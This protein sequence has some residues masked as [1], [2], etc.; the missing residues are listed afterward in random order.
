MR[1]SLK[2]ND[3]SKINT[4]FSDKLDDLFESLKMS[5][6]DI[7]Q[8]LYLLLQIKGCETKKK[9]KKLEDCKGKRP[10]LDHHQDA[11]KLKTEAKY[12][13]TNIL[14]SVQANETRKGPD[15]MFWNALSDEIMNQ[16]KKIESAK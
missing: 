9:K 16:G 13:D 8:A 5:I 14:L 1:K 11:K 12:T 6:G 2:L 7:Q 4:Q 3:K 15:P 10:Y